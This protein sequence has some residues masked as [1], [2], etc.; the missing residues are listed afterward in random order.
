MLPLLH[1][2]VIQG[3]K[4]AFRMIKIVKFLLMSPKP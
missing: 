4:V 2:D 3:I 1:P